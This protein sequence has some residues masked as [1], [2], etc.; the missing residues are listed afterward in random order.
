MRGGPGRTR[1]PNQTVISALT[2][3]EILEKTM[4]PDCF[5]GV[6]DTYLIAPHACTGRARVLRHVQQ[7]STGLE[8]SMRLLFRTTHGRVSP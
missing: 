4:F 3:P 6:P 8:Y 2:G 1:T 5:A 7:A